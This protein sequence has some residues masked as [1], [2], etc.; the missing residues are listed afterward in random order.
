LQLSGDAGE[1]WLEAD[2]AATLPEGI[3][4][5]YEP[6][7]AF[8]GGGRL[9][10]SFLG[11]AGPPPDP[12]GVYVAASD[13]RGQTFSQPR[14]F[15][16]IRAAT[17][18]MT[19][20]QGQVAMVWI[21]PREERDWGQGPPWPVGGQVRAALGGVD[22]AS[23]QVV[24]AD[25]PGLVAGTSVASDPESGHM[26]VAYYELPTSARAGGGVE[27]LVGSGPWRLMVA[28]RRDDGGFQ[29]PVEVAELELLGQAASDSELRASTESPSQVLPLL[30]SRWGIAEPGL[31]VRNNTVC[32]SWTTSNQ[33]RLRPMASCTQKTGEGWHEPVG[34]LDG[35]DRDARGW[36][37]QIT[38]SP[39]GRVQTAF[40]ARE[41][42]SPGVDVWYA[43]RGGLAGPFEER[44]ELT[45]RSSQP[46]TTPR[47]G[48]YGTRLGLAGGDE[49]AVAMWAD[50]R[51]A[52]RLRKN[53]SIFAAT[54]DTSG[55]TAWPWPLGGLMAAG[56]GLAVA[57]LV[58]GR[59][60]GMWSRRGVGASQAR[61]AQP[62]G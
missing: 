46:R 1:S 30:V 12:E 56:G 34:L 16:D 13:D 21:P 59:R 10:F 47:P 39:S 19:A 36:M 35:S 52:S 9:L 31:S 42:D 49:Q 38:I 14:L 2:A 18:R 41:S 15:V 22:G 11:M 24:V 62:E 57:G 44:V 17:A 53:Q 5:C 37:P 3:K 40:Y 29:K 60:H 48:W 51:N 7:V 8:D 25:P 32:V 28:R 45:A 20:S 33:G 23:Q 58:F 26:A 4:A 43:A 61:V 6:Q 50:S 55:Q 27:S 54:V